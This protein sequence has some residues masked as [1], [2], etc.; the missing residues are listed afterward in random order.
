MA[1]VAIDQDAAQT[2]LA[3]L[4]EGDLERPTV[5]VGVAADRTR[6]AAIETQ[7]E[8]E[9]NRRFL[10]SRNDHETLPVVGVEDLGLEPPAAAILILQP[11]PGRSVIGLAFALA[12]RAG[13]YL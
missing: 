12:E 6:H 8:P 7:R 5:G 9:S 11:R 10:A 1:T 13:E 4:A 3:H 2:H